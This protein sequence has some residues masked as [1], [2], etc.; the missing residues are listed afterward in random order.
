[1]ALC[2]NCSNQLPD[3]NA[4]CLSCGAVIDISPK[5][6]AKILK[7]ERVVRSGLGSHLREDESEAEIK[8]SYTKRED[9]Q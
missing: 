7:S 1:M 3:G 4:I 9:Q 2:P 8:T 5:F 6:N